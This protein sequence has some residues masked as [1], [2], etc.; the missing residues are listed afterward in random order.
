MFPPSHHTLNPT[1]PFPSLSY[2]PTTPVPSPCPCPHHALAVAPTLPRTLAFAHLAPW[3]LFAWHALTLVPSPHTARS[4]SPC[5]CSHCT[6]ALTLAL[7]PCFCSHCAIA[8]VH[9]ALGGPRPNCTLAFPHT[10]PRP[11][12][13]LIPRPCAL[14][15][16]STTP[17]L[18]LHPRPR[19][20]L[21]HACPRPCPHS[22]STLPLPLPSLPP[23]HCYLA[24]AQQEQP[25]DS[26]PLL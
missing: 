17:L 18:P 7:R 25:L 26:P 22:H 10:T 9:T 1:T 19:R 8:F 3:P 20:N 11:S 16:V 21:T 23:C 2:A 12:S 15:L 24:L 14:A 6:L 13:L 4:P 5:P